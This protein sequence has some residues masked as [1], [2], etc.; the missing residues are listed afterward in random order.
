MRTTTILM[1]ATLALAAVPS[2]SA[3]PVS[4]CVDQGV[5]EGC[6]ERGDDPANPGHCWHAYH[7]WVYRPTD[8]G[9]LTGAGGSGGGNQHCL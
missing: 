2:A 1:L 8:G 4:A 5:V 9:V 3:T 7:V 6:Y